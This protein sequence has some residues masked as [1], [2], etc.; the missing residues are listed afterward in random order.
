MSKKIVLIT[1]LVLV[2]LTLVGC[3]QKQTPE[4]ILNEF[5]PVM[6]DAL[7]SGDGTAWVE[8]F[9]DD[10]TMEVPALAPQPVA[11]KDMIEAAMWPGVY[12]AAGES[13]IEIVQLEVDGNS[14][15]VYLM[16]T[17]G[18]TGDFPMQDLIEFND[19]GKIQSY[20]VNVGVPAP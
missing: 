16:Y 18:L 4:E 11:G 9:A 10:A 1:V 17:G 19:E 13:S 2:A 8:Y 15:T 6:E 20:V 7:A 12:G 5:Y 3:G 14:A